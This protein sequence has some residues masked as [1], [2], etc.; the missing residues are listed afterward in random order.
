ME[1]VNGAEMAMGSF[2]KRFIKIGNATPIVVA[3]SIVMMM[4]KLV[5]KI[6]YH[7]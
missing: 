3:K 6:A 1:V 2:L 4:V 5:V 7:K